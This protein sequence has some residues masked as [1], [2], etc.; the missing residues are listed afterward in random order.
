MLLSLCVCACAHPC[1]SVHGYVRENLDTD[2]DE[3]RIS[4]VTIC[5]FVL[6]L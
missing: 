6:L 2:E 1:L 5:G 3:R 4:I